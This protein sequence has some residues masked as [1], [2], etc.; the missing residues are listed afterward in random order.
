VLPVAA[1]ALAPVAAELVV[2]SEEPPQPARAAARPTVQ[3]SASVA[4]RVVSRVDLVLIQ[5][6]P[7]ARLDF[8]F[9]VAAGTCSGADNPGARTGDVPH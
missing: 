7:A 2:T 6:P 5:E 8:E 1:A 9:I 4:P 3:T